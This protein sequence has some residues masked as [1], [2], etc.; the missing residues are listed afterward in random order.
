MVGAE[1]GAE[2]EGHGRPVSGFLDH[3]H[4]PDITD[5]ITPCKVQI[6]VCGCLRLRVQGAPSPGQIGDGP[7]APLLE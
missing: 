4:H 2:V 1:P 6:A 3:I 7:F 5:I